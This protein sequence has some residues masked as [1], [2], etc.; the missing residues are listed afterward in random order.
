MPNQL[1]IAEAHARMNAGKLTAVQLAEACL[2][3]VSAREADVRAWVHINADEVLAQA[4]A[5]DAEQRRGARKSALHGIPVGIKDIIDVAGMPAEYGSPIYAGHRASADAAC[6]VALRKAG[7]IIMGKTVTTEFAMR[8]PN[9]TR[10]PLNLA[11]TPGGSSSGSAAGVADFMM[12]LG[13]GTQTGG[14]VLRPSSYCGVVGFK[15]S[16]CV[17]NRVGVKPN[18]ESLDTVGLIARGVA[19][20]ALSLPVVTECVA[21]VVDAITKPRIAFC[22]TPQ[23]LSAEPATVA[24]IEAVAATLARAGASVTEYQLPPAFD[25]MAAAHGVIND[26]EAYR[27]LS[28]ELRTAPEKISASLQPRIPRWAACTMDDYV[29]AQQTVAD[30]RRLL[31]DVF[32]DYDALLVPSAPGEAPVTLNSTG[33]AT[34]N[35]IWTA[36]HVPAITL[37][38]GK[39]PNSLPVGVQLV[40][41]Y[42]AD[43]ALLACAAWA[44]G[45]LP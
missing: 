36:L 18:S 23:W 22:R 7:A 11:H 45:R 21:P 29:Q 6:V 40:G 39:G 30:C 24:T 5:C 4:R 31:R 42:G 28:H 1:P 8:H 38:A 44:E 13:L 19:D 41:A 35:A 43:Y 25:A 16:F 9:K 37:P 17:I 3:R 34:F 15:P 20:I 2:A 10:N 33:E 27:A 14:S 26:Y 12:P 32:R